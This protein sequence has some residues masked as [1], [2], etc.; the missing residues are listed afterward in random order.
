MT[1]SLF[2]TILKRGCH[3]GEKNNPVIPLKFGE[4]LGILKISLKTIFRRPDFLFF[5]MDTVFEHN[6][7][8][9]CRPPTLSREQNVSGDGLFS[10]TLRYSSVWIISLVGFS[11]NPSRPVLPP[12][13]S[14]IRSDTGK[15]TLTPFDILF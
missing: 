6:D 3:I 7:R 5:R 12:L 13:N 4:L 9:I 15:N 11:I 2:L 8:S 14:L 10:Q 1:P